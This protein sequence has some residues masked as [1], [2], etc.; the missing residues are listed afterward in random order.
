MGAFE[1][2]E[3]FRVMIREALNPKA[4]LATTASSK[5]AIGKPRAVRHPFLSKHR[6]SKK[7]STLSTAS[8]ASDRVPFFAMR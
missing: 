5:S 3:T 7:D 4:K 2:S 1:K 6:T 8:I